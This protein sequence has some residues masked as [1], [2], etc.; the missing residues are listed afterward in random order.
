MW[1]EAELILNIIIIVSLISAWRV[2]YLGPYEGEL[3]WDGLILSIMSVI[4]AILGIICWSLKLLYIAIFM[5]KE[6]FTALGII[7]FP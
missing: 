5:F 1:E 4:I 2:I 6:T 7:V 3:G